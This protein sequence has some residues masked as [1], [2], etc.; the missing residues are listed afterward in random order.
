[1]AT[2]R[3][4]PKPE[5]FYTVLPGTCRW[6][7]TEVGLTKTGKESKSRW[8]IECLREYYLLSRPSYSRKAVW[9]RDNGVCNTC[10]TVCENKGPNAWEMDH[11]VP[12]INANGDIKYWRIGN[13]QT[14]CKQCHKDKTSSECTARALTLREMKAQKQALPINDDVI[15]SEHVVKLI[16]IR[17]MKEK[18]QSPSI[19]ELREQNREPKDS[20]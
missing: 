5:Y 4:V 12:L 11:I 2:H 8:H 1:M 19:R 17:E 15:S 16:T 9:L 6:C 10:G 18:K 3:N 20:R 13:L 7:N 14:L